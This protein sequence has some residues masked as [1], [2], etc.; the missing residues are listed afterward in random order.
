[1][2]AEKNYC[3]SFRMGFRFVP[4][5]LAKRFPTDRFT[6]IPRSKLLYSRALGRTHAQLFTVLCGAAQIAEISVERD[7][8]GQ[9]AARGA[10]GVLS[11]STAASTEMRETIS[12]ENS[13]IVHLNIL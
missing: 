10:F 7:T 3:A 11:K 12:S 9:C 4:S 8:R 13:N 5:C 6:V 1:M 2:E